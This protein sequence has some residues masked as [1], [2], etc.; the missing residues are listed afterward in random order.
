[1]TFADSLHLK[2]HPIPQKHALGYQSGE[3]TMMTRLFGEY[4]E[5]FSVCST[6]GY[7]IYGRVLK[8]QLNKL[9]FNFRFRTFEDSWGLIGKL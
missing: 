5:G 6:K 3:L 7:I 1:M 9:A 2:P 4:A 8:Y